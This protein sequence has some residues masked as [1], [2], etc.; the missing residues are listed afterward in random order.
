MIPNRICNGIESTIA[1]MGSLLGSI[2]PNISPKYPAIKNIPTV[3]NIVMVVATKYFFIYLYSFVYISLSST[4]AGFI[5]DPL[6][7]LVGS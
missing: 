1:G 5:G 3:E 4:R 2:K 6:Q 7:H